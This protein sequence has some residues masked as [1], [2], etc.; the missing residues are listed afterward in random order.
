MKFS[1]QAI[2]YCLL[3]IL[4]MLFDKF[5]KLIVFSINALYVYLNI[6]LM[7][8]FSQI[9]LS[10]SIAKILLLI[11]IPMVI[12]AIPALIYRLIKGQMMPHFFTI[13]WGIW[14][15]IVLSHILIQ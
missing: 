13:T 9:G 4:I 11:A 15:V 7:K 12:S 14:L 6:L 1:H 3:S 5:P 2:I 8:L 10:G